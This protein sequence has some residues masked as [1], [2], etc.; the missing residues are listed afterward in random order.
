MEGS[1]ARV[2]VLHPEEP[3]RLESGKLIELYA[4]LGETGAEAVVARAMEEI[5]ARVAEMERLSEAG[6]FRDVAL[7]STR[8]TAVAGRI[9]MTTMSTVAVDVLRAALSG[10]RHGLAATLARLFRIADRSIGAVN[11]LGRAIS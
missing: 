9:G 5:C 7:S 1:V 2:T 4:R 6:Q 11:D 8:L 10:D 3:V